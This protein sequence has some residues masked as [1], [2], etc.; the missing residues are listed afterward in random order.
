MNTKFYILFI[1]VLNAAIAFAQPPTTNTYQQMIETAEMSAD[2]G[3][4]FNALEWYE[5]AYKEEKNN[6]LALNIADLSVMVTKDYKKAERIYSR[7]LKM[8]KEG[9]NS[10]LRYDLGMVLKSQGKY[11]EA[12]EELRVFISET[13]DEELRKKAVVAVNGIARLNEYEENIATMVAFAG[14]KINKGQSE[15]SPVLFTDGT[16]Y[17]GGFDDNKKIE[18]EENGESTTAAIFKATRDDKGVFVDPVQ[19]GE[20][21]N[22]PGYHT[23]NPSFSADGRRMY[24]TRALLRGNTLTESKIFVSYRQDAGWS[25]ATELKGVNGDYIATHPRSGDLFG[26]EVLYFTSDMDGGYGGYDIYYATRKGDG[27][28]SLPVNLGDKI[29]TSGDEQSPFY[30]DGTLYFSSNGHPG[31]G[32]LDIFYSIWD[33][34]TWSDVTNIGYNY[35]T[36]YDDKSMYFSPDG[37]TGFLTSNR[38]D[39]NKKRL[40][41]KTCC[42]DIYQFSIAELVIDL[43]ATVVDEN[44]PL[45]GAA[46][47]LTDMSAPEDID[48]QSKTN[49]T[50]HEFNFLLVPDHQYRATITREG[51]YPD[52]ISFNTIGILDDYTVKKEVKLKPRPKEPEVEIVTINEPIRLNNIYY[53]FDDDKILPDAEPSLEY[54]KSLLD[55]YP[56]MVI[57]LSSHTDSQGPKRY[58]RD[59]SQ[60]RAESAKTWLEKKGID[61]KRVVA[62]GYGEARILNQCKDKVECTDEEHRFNR[63]TE[64]KILAGPETIEIKREIISTQK[65]VKSSIQYRDYVYDTVPVIAFE[66]TVIDLDTILQGEVYELLYWFTNKGKE[67]LKIDL[68]TSCKCTDIEWTQGDI[69]PGNKGVI[70]AVFNS[71]DQGPGPVEKVIDILSNTDPIVTE[72][73]F[74]AVI[75]PDHE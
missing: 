15:Y 66:E 9:F 42:D 19:L 46:F 45:N 5:K 3:D 59:L 47:E 51:Y 64:F 72:V 44:G 39:K 12:N 54:L 62:K 56:D 60:R 73:W 25:A 33:G 43:L 29:N 16:L 49:Q 55:Q 18:V 58:N 37:L 26:N 36:S 67:D 74:K 23:S 35:N 4:Y 11:V 53:D 30:Q 50:G 38:P 65:K 2:S 28:Y 52:T 20:H 13:D 31:M 75:L 41:G 21:I 69:A 70:R 68:V 63:R 17:Y 8:D 10:D 14:K 1:L 71:T 32:G 22:R 27:E 61:D 57:E 6:E 7:I 24:F 34:S 48:T 40:E